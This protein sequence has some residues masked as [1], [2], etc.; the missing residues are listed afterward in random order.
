MSCSLTWFY[1]RK[2]KNKDEKVTCPRPTQR[3]PG[4]TAKT[5]TRSPIQSH[6]LHDTPRGL[7]E[8][9]TVSSA[10]RSAFCSFHSLIL[11]RNQDI[12]K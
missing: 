3:D 9:V 8:N 1:R 10:F 11:Y 2:L 4:G 6:A 5:R 7:P 12:K